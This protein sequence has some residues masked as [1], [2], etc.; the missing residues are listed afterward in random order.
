MG[1]LENLRAEQAL[2]L[3]SR[4]GDPGSAGRTTWAP[5]TDDLFAR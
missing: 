3:L 2:F 1:R 4:P 5:A